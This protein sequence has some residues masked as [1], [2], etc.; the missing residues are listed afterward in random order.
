MFGSGD[1]WDNHPH[2]FGKVR[3]ILVSYIILVV[4]EEKSVYQDFKISFAENPLDFYY[5]H[6]VDC[7]QHCTVNGVIL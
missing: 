4:Y 2:D 7:N 3:Y 6:T 5:N 1:F